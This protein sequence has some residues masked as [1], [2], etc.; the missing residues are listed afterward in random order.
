MMEMRA[1]ERGEEVLNARAEMMEAVERRRR[2]DDMTA[3]MGFLGIVDDDVD[4][5]NRVDDVD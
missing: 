4:A 1:R 5:T 2:K 3:V